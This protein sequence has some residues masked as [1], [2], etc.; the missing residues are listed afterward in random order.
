MSHDEGDA[1]A[2]TSG[3]PTGTPIVQHGHIRL[4][5]AASYHNGFRGKRT[6]LPG[7]QEPARISEPCTVN[8][9]VFR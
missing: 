4:T 8:L 5:R 9:E 1:A 7:G 3:L 6:P 2:R